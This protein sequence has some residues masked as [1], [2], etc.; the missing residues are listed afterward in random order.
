MSYKKLEASC[1]KLLAFRTSS[2]A[3][4]AFSE[5]ITTTASADVTYMHAM[6][7][8][9]PIRQ[10][11]ASAVRAT[12]TATDASEILLQSDVTPDMVSKEVTS[13]AVESVCLQK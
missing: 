6:Q 11:F 9:F 4:Y 1:E 10:R 8:Q 12:I 13:N 2:S 3:I 7:R 5:T